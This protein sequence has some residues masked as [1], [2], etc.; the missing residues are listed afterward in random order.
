[1]QNIKKDAVKTVSDSTEPVAETAPEILQVKPEDILPETV[2]A[3]NINPETIKPVQENEIILVVEAVKPAYKPRFKMQQTPKPVVEQ[4][5]EAKEDPQK[6]ETAETK[7]PYK[8]RFQMKNI[9]KPIQP[10]D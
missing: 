3:S 4:V 5:S 7:Q 6:P 9:N 2:V 10:E 1:M 8:P